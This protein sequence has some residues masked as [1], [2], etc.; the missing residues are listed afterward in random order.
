MTQQQTAILGT[1]E[2][3]Y[4][5]AFSHTFL[6]LN[7]TLQPRMDLFEHFQQEIIGLF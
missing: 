2:F 6:R 1:H 3:N 7:L 5:E 4:L